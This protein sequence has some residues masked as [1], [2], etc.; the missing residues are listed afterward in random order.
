MLIENDLE[1][2]ISKSPK[3]RKSHNDTM[4]ARYLLNILNPASSKPA[5][6]DGS[7][8]AAE[9]NASIKIIQKRILEYLNG[10]GIVFVIN[11]LLH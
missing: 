3:K 6:A 8:G 9:V 2:V 4:P 11:I 7:V 1:I 5:R 10:N